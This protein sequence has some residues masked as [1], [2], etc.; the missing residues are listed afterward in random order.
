[1]SA[2]HGTKKQ[3]DSVYPSC[4][5]WLKKN[6]CLGDFETLVGQRCEQ[7]KLW[8]HMSAI[9]LAAQHHAELAQHRSDIG[10]FGR[11]TFEG[12]VARAQRVAG[13]LERLYS[14]D[15]G[16]KA[17]QQAARAGSVAEFRNIPR[18]LRLIAAEAQT[19]YKKTSHRKKPLF[20]ETVAEL[21]VYI[22]QIT[23]N[24]RDKE[25]SGLIGVLTS[26]VGYS[27]DDQRSWRH[28]H[29]ALLG[30]ITR[31]ANESLKSKR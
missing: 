21:C 8:G 12:F 31:R 6:G 5:E 10:G 3:M 16:Q 4:L 22:K 19:I 27:G 30:R 23:G 15:L 11:E 14:S 17:I 1:M 13:E 2:P 29:Q 25:V 7:T 9:M 18:Q 24:W 28:E 20:D 26:R